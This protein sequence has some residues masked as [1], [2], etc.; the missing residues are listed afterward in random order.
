MPRFRFQ[1]GLITLLGLTQTGSA[2]EPLPGLIRKLGARN[3]HERIAAEKELI[4][5]GADG[6]RLAGIGTQSSDPEIRQRS[7]RLLKQLQRLAFLEQRE[8][9]FADPWTAPA[10]LAPGWEA[11]QSLVGDGPASRG[12]YV[13]M[14]EQE[15]DLMLAVVLKPDTWTYDLERRC[16]DLRT[17]FDRRSVQDLNQASIVTL[18]FLS[19]YPGARPSP[20]SSG[21]VSSLISE[22]E[23]SNTI[24]RATEEE[25]AVYEAL[26]SHWVQQNG[27]TSAASRLQLAIRFKLPA[28]IVPAREIV[29]KRK[30][31]GQSRAQ[32]QHA[33]GFLARY[34]D[35]SDVV[36][37][38][39]LLDQDRLLSLQLNDATEADEFRKRIPRTESGRVETEKDEANPPDLVINDMALQALVI[40]T[41]QNPD[42]YGFPPAK[43]DPERR[44]I[45]NSPG[46]SS[47]TDRRNA[48]ARWFSWRTEHANQLNPGSLDASEGV[49]G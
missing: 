32:L 18:L 48:L 36:D 47:E 26:L 38:E 20:V 4:H 7:Q 15:P 10:E 11:F 30:T 23:F 19:V 40:L 24:L 39:A 21:T 44:S 46:F 43:G 41:Q 17:F 29:T 31:L 45:S 27:Q 34:G 22:A 42:D 6:L 2:S 12:L 5:Q 9:I 14:I 25:R 3:F 1:L 37:L 8:R 16:A 35:L 28:G 49:G 13:R 33:V